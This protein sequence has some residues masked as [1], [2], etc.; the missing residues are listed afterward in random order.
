MSRVNAIHRPS[1]IH[2]KITGKVK[3]DIFTGSANQH[4]RNMQQTYLHH[5][6]FEKQTS[7]NDRGN[8]DSDEN[9]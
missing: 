2:A 1:S 8:Q 7:T 9:K 5:T 4:G 3:I 6:T